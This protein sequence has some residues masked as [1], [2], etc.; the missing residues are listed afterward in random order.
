MSDSAQNPNELFDIVDASDRVIGR[1]PRHL[2]HARGLRHRAIHVWLCNAGRVF[3]QRRSKLKD[4]APGCW[5]SSCSGHL[6]T[7]ETYDQSMRREL[8]EELGI[9]S[10]PPVWPVLKV[11]ARPETGMEFVWLYRGLYDGP[12]SLNPAEVL[13]GRWFSSNEVDS[14][15]SADPGAFAPAF[16]FLWNRLRTNAAFDG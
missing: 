2:V 15:L 10:R 14:A 5:D 12:F 6:D 11:S 16:S 1:E 3:L 8:S 13:D 7:G 9:H 4:S